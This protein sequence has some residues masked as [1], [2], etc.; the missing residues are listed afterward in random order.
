MDADH[1][2][3]FNDVDRLVEILNGIAVRFAQPDQVFSQRSMP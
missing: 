2:P 1:M 3:I